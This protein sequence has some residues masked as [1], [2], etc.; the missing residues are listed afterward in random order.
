MMRDEQ[1][2]HHDAGAER[3]Q[4][5]DTRRRRLPPVAVGARGASYVVSRCHL[6]RH[7]SRRCRSFRGAAA[8]DAGPWSMSTPLLDGRPRP[9]P[10]RSRPGPAAAPAPAA[11]PPAAAR[12]TAGRRTTAPRPPPPPAAAP[13]PRGTTARAATGTT[14]APPPA[15]PRTAA[16]ATAATTGAA[17]CRRRRRRHR[18]H[19]WAAP[20]RI[21]WVVAAAPTV[22]PRPADVA[23]AARS[24][25]SL[26]GGLAA[27]CRPACPRR[28]SWPRSCP[29]PAPPAVA[30]TIGTMNRIRAGSANSASTSMVTPVTM[31][32]IW[33]PAVLA[34][35]VQAPAVVRGRV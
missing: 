6:V 34:G 32:M 22:V 26:A 1:A 23:A 2:A 12:A 31:F 35:E 5:G 10:P 24:P 17:T 4:A 19:R 8:L 27:P 30:A 29:A 33:P 16:A 7:P 9:P 11:A 21:C 18:R 15:P 28:P 14:A 3:A 13:P 20:L 25:L